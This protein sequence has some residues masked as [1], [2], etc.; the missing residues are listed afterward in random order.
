ML[1]Q[2]FKAGGIKIKR[3]KGTG[4]QLKQNILLKT[5]QKLLYQTLNDLKSLRHIK[6]KRC[7]RF[8]FL[9]NTIRNLPEITRAKLLGSDRILFY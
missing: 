8:T 7:T 3:Y 5:K 2:K 6:Y 9:E 4:L 1:K